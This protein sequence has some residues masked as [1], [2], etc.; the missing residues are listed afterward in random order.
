MIPGFL[1]VALGPSPFFV[2]PSTFA[3]V[4]KDLASLHLAVLSL[5]SWKAI[6]FVFLFGKR[7]ALA[8]FYGKRTMSL[9]RKNCA[10]CKRVHLSRI[11][12]ACHGGRTQDEQRRVRSEESGRCLHFLRLAAACMQM[13]LIYLPLQLFHFSTFLLAFFSLASL[14]VFIV[15]HFF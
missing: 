2:T 9:E 14:F 6:S 1:V 8:P 12:R 3:Y 10:N 4:G 5:K 11:L 13:S 7:G 15:L